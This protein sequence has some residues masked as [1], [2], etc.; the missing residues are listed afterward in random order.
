MTWVVYFMLLNIKMIFS[1][2][3][4][5]VTEN[6]DEFEKIYFSSK[7]NKCQNVQRRNDSKNKYINR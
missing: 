6:E 1:G 7:F 5:S 3:L 2:N 4:K